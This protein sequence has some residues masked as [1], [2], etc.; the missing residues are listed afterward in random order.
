[1][2]ESP[3]LALHHI[4]SELPGIHALSRAERLVTLREEG[5]VSQEVLN[6][7]TETLSPERADLMTENVVGEFSLPLSV[8][9]NFRV[10]S[11]DY[12]IPMAIEE[13]SVVAAASKAAKLARV[14]GGF[15][16]QASSGVMICQLLLMDLSDP[17][18]VQQQIMKAKG[19]LLAELPVSQSVKA[20]GG[21]PQDLTVRFLPTSE[22]GPLLVVHLH[23]NV[24]DAMG[25]NIVNAAGEQ[26][27]P[28]VADLTGGQVAISIL[29]NLANERMASAKVLYP[30]YV[31]ANDKE[32]AGKEI[33]SICRADE[34]ARIDPF[35]AATHNKGI[36]NGIGGL[37]LATGNDWRAVEAGAHA[38]AARSGC[39]R[40]LTRWTHLKFGENL[41]SSWH[42]P[43]GKGDRV[44][45]LYGEIS[46]PLPLGTVGGTPGSHPTARGALAL[47][48]NPTAGRLA[49]IGAAVGLAQN[50][51][52]LRALTKEG[53]QRG[54]MNL[55]ARQIALNA[56]IP[57]RMVSS[58]VARMVNARTINQEAALQSWRELQATEDSHGSNAT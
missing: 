21:G 17:Q 12:L 31:L 9:T 55:H 18:A 45:A 33:Q 40:G 54:H 2:T 48:G 28:L 57:V 38:W 22:F 3:D 8:A 4:N 51:A 27:A 58:V 53:I 20:A 42:C 5:G 44:P 46:L 32:T 47:L 13:P 56:G 11:T 10:D 39:Y 52:A 6:L 7:L 34:W 25:A 50:F 16:T 30:W 14:G 24:G 43:G 41:P 1:M 29:T 23:F 37:A 36:L 26:L 15:I 35:R 49:R 19:R